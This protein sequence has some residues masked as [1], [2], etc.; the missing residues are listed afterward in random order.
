MIRAAGLLCLLLGL[1][2]AP[3]FAMFDGHAAGPSLESARARYI[4]ALELAEAGDWRRFE[5]ERAALDDYPLTAYLDYE[6]LM[7][8]LKQTSGSEAR[9]FVDAQSQSP[10][11]IRFLGHYLRTAGTSR[12]W[13]DYLAAAQSE[14]NSESLRCYYGRAKRARGDEQEAWSLAQRLWVSP[15]SVDDACDPLFKLWRESGGLNDEL[16]WE[17]ARLAYGARESGLV[18]YVASLGS[19]AIRPQLEALQRS[20]REPQKSL[21]LSRGLPAPAR[22]EVLALALERYSRYDP[23]RALRQWQSLDPSM[24]DS[25]QR[26]QVEAAVAFRGLLEREVTVR[27]WADAKLPLW[28]DDRLTE[29]RLRWAIADS[30]WQAILAL[31]PALSDGARED[32]TWGYWAARALEASGRHDE[33]QAQYAKV[34]RERSYYGFLSADR[35]GLPY[36]F[37]DA[38]PALKQA[39]SEVTLATWATDALWRVYELHAIQEERLAQAEWNYTLQRLDGAEQLELARIAQSQGWHRLS[40]DAANASRSWDA[41]DLR[42]PLAFVDDFYARAA[43]QSLPVS[44]LMAIARRESAFSPVARS[45]VGARGLMQLMPATGRSVAKSVGLRASTGD[46]YQVDYNI[47]LGS[48]YYQQLLERFDGNRAVALAAY[49]AGPNRVKNWLGQGLA[50]D[51]WIETIPYRETRDYV[52]AVLA[53]SVV[54]DY[55]LGERAQLMSAAELQSRH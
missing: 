28:K 5:A 50:L 1:G 12:R 48:A 39:T 45:P 41:L 25:R 24:V 22:S 43:D 34:A 32:A 42:F 37:R 27:D 19:P 6:R 11:G 52:K 20:Y 14:P 46:L 15:S 17:R 31:L 21:V 7:S 13:G 30:D 23:A 8:R 3:A 33:A 53:Y 26:E 38:S 35:L 16:V 2:S 54:F 29:L 49:N 47:T 4:R 10:L 9:S 18:R 51:A 40:I 36:S 55:R 44:E